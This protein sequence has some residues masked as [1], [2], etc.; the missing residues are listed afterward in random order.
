VVAI[1]I[2]GMSVLLPGAPDLAT[3]WHNLQHGVDAIT[4]VPE[5]RIDPVFFD[6]SGEN[7]LYC[8]RGGFVDEHARVDVA[9]FG[10]MPSSAAASEPDQLLALQVAA[11]AID[12]AGGLDG[13]RRRDRVGVV[14]G[15]GGY[16]TSGLARLDNQLRVT[17]QVMQTLREVLPDIS[18]DRLR[19]VRAAFESG[20]GPLRP[21]SA[22]GMV[23]NL[24]ASRI[25]NR[26]D[27]HGPAYVV[28]AACASSLL[29]VDQ[30][31]AELTGGRCDVM[32]AGGTHHCQDIVLWNAF[33][34]LGALSA[35]GRS[36]PFHRDADGI[37]IGEGT[38]M[39]VL[40]R[41]DDA[42]RDG[43][44]VYAVIRGTGVASDGRAGS[45]VNPEPGGQ[46]LAVRRAW[47]AAGLDP[48]EPGS[49]GLLEAH[50]TATKAGD[51]A[52]LTTITR[53]FGPAGPHRAVLG[54]VKSMIGHTMPAAGIASLVK[55]ALAVHHGVLLPTLHCDEP[56]PSL[57]DTRFRVTD[58]AEPWQGHRRAAVNAFGFGGINAHVVLEQ[59][60]SAT[61]PVVVREPERVLL[62]S[63]R[64]PDDMAALL[65]TDDAR[66]RD[67]GSAVPGCRLG[68]V[69]PTAKN[70]AL[71]RKAV[72]KRLPWHGRGDVWFSPEPLL[73]KGKLAFVFTGLEAGFEPRVEDVA[74][75]FRLAVPPTSAQ[76]V[77]RH[78]GSVFAVG[79]LLDAALG[80]LGIRPDAVAGNSVGEWNAMLTAGVLAESTADTFWSREP[81]R[82]PD[83]AF[84]ALGCPAARLTEVLSGHPGVV[85]SHENSPNQSIV[86]GPPGQVEEV[87]RVLR[88][89]NVFGQVLPFRSGFHTPMLEPFLG[90]L[91]EKIARTPMHPAKV[92]IWS[93]TTASP[94]PAEEGEIRD[95][96][97][98]HL[99]EPV[100]FRSTIEAMH[101]DG[102]RVFVQ[103][104]V[105]Q[106]TS[107]I[108]DTLRGR[109]HLAVAS[110]VPH[111]DGLGQLRR[112]AT[113]VWVEGGTPDLTAVPGFATA[114]RG[115]ALDLGAPLVR[116]GP[117]APRLSAPAERT[118]ATALADLGPLVGAEFDALLRETSSAATDVLTAIR[119]QR[120][121][122]TTLRVCAETMPYLMDHALVRQ[123]EGWPDTTDRHPV[124]PAT[125]T[126]RFM[127]D[128]AERATGRLVTTVDDLR[129]LSWLGAAPATDVEVVTRPL[130][131]D[132]VEVALTGFA[133]ATMTVAARHPGRA[134]ARWD[135][136]PCEAPKLTAAAVYD[137]RWMFHGPLYRGLVET[138]GISD[139][140]IRATLRATTAPGSLLDAA[141]QLA[142]QW[143][144]ERTPVHRILFPMDISRIRFF[145]VEPG[146]DEE[147]HCVLLVREVTDDEVS[148]DVQLSVRGQVW[149]EVTGW[150]DRRFHCAPEHEQAYYFPE[151]NT[152]SR[153]RDDGWW[154][155]EEQWPTVASRMLYVRKYLNTA[156]LA[157]YERCSPR[158]RRQWL[159]GRIAAK[160]AV[161]SWLWENG[162]GPLFP[163][164]IGIHTGPAGRAEAHGVHGLALPELE[165]SIATD[166][167]GRGS[168]RV[169]TRGVS[170]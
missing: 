160:D 83:V 109:P 145:G 16:L 164:E 89:Q 48:A 141:G 8:R 40:K 56:H 130:P 123:R 14:L 80:R 127:V 17:E 91:R 103:V 22:Y 38:G 4:D 144:V 84:A 65:A 154:H 125:T 70:L 39:V 153:P 37:L 116:L 61:P 29:A 23:P 94:Y 132:R 118:T 60:R 136:M 161:R 62:L 10:M 140:G 63:A 25:A 155:V 92:P 36:R 149:A 117:S 107:L 78:G 55:A 45:V 87:V 139:T 157:D 133:T 50:G 3:Y 7:R 49:V 30:A 137:E 18:D 1:A 33:S 67:T 148:F 131:G 32:L 113:A 134:P 146:P 143:M 108:D 120:P 122:R 165:L 27:L 68:V 34:R 98:R 167:P 6:G 66:I 150:R 93:A 19:S 152:L 168:A 170:A 31:V 162:W 102:A 158:E 106:L 75:H 44:R 124:V 5:H 147:V 20:T 90:S 9:R 97:I 35:S 24:A 58:T 53:V 104:G 26:L 82:V 57:R 86:C 54:S 51:Q 135:E 46:E 129:L 81:F 111:H 128:A 114:P 163:A 41:L 138:L 73:A 101:D 71:A 119:A 151:T 88:E 105:G 28:D 74:A 43:D 142:G 99:L 47:E 69:G 52:E 72:A 100:R 95:L 115:V 42:E 159:L 121:A 2:V 126:L 110:N 169:L 64:T 12:D 85:L 96:F 77:T 21:E 79:R 156:E 15:R 166:A 59:H 112:V 76:D 11:S 13:L